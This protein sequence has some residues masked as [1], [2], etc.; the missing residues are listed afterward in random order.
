MS[1]ATTEGATPL[2]V[3]SLQLVPLGPKIGVA[4]SGSRSTPSTI[5]RLFTTLRLVLADLAVGRPLPAHTKTLKGEPSD[6]VAAS[7]E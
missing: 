3:P 1:S 4:A 5:P 7:V 6:R 2:P